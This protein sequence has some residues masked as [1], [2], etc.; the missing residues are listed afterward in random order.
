M[1]FV[2]HSPT[3]LASRN[4][5]NDFTA[6]GASNPPA[7]RDFQP[8]LNEKSELKAW[9]GAAADEQRH[10]AARDAEHARHK[11][12]L[13]HAP[14]HE[15][16]LGDANDAHAGLGLLACRYSHRRAPRRLRTKNRTPLACG[17]STSR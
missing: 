12:L 11:L 10:V 16:A 9:T 4:A 17:S 3:V 13:A 2:V 1:V 6:S 8:I 5:R 15:R 7:S 14:K